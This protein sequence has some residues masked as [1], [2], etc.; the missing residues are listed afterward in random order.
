MILTSIESRWLIGVLLD[1]PVQGVVGMVE[2]LEPACGFKY[3]IECHH[4]VYGTDACL[5]DH[6]AD[7]EGAFYLAHPMDCSA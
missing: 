6:V 7:I 1:E 2:F 3:P 5:K 4:P